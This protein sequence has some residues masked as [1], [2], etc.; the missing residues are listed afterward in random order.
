MAFD[1]NTNIASLQ[2]QQYLRTNSNFQAKTINEVTSGLRIVSSGDDAAGLAIANGYRSDQSVISQGVRNANDGLSQL[3]IAD[4]GISNISQLLDRART[5]ATQSASGTF[6]GDRGVLNSEFQSV[7]GEINR[8]AQAIGLNQGGILAKSLSVFIGGG[9]TSGTVS[10]N[11]NGS[12][13]LDLSKSTVDAKSL[14]LTGF[15]A[16]GTSTDIGNNAKAVNVSTILATS[17]NTTTEAVNGYTTFNFFGQGFSDT[18]GAGKLSVSVNLSSVTDANTLVN[19]VNSAI[20][21]T[22]LAGSP[23]ATAFK[24]ANVTASLVTDA[25]G[26][27][28]AFSSSATAFQAQAGDNV[29]SALLGNT[30]SASSPTGKSVFATTTASGVAAG[31]TAPGAAEAV[32]LRVSLNGVST[33]YA[34]GLATTDNTAAKVLAKV[35][36]ALGTTSGITASLDGSSNLVFKSSTGS[37]SLNV[38]TAG[39]ISNSLGLGTFQA[40]TQGSGTF[41]YT[42]TTGTGFVAATATQ[43][44][45]VSINGGPV[46]DLGAVVSGAS[47][48]TAIAALNVALT[49]NSSARASG[50]TASNNGGQIQITSLN[51]DNFRL[52]SVGGVATTF[53]FAAGV[54]AGAAGAAS[55]LTGTFAVAPGTDASGESQTGLLNFTGI[56][57]IGVT[58]AVT[59]SA[60]DQS[61]TLHSSSIT[62]D[63]TN[64]SNLDTAVAS[65]NK[66]LQQ[67][68][69]S[70]LQSVVAV[71][72]YNA[73]SNT[74]GIRFVSSAPSFQASLGTTANGNAAAATTVGISDG[75]QALGSQQGA[76]VASAVNGNGATA[77]ITNQSSAQAAVNT[78]ANAVSALGRAQAVVGKG[79]NQFNYAINLAQSQLTNLASAESQ[80]R[81]A[82]LASQA[83]N[84]TKAQILLQAGVAALAQANSA[85]QAVLALLKG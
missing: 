70:T 7:V 18:S 10:A 3:Q 74:E 31:A 27:H 67:T 80:I 35:N 50:L 55:S 42:S 85:P 25:N 81:D 51:G 8:Q 62:L 34:V 72:D 23:Q 66:Q 37:T 79:E 56:N 12:V 6:T 71:K 2:A 24:N 17:A 76:L 22:G 49:A 15:Q 28:L 44:F 54:T 4:G 20:Q 41:N 13:A 64:A 61:G 58:Q 75:S 63:T 16:V 1:I 30:V 60:T 57:T 78:L 65:I 73:T 43:N 53:G 45:Q 32:T 11:D 68:N 33:D 47:E 59:I 39:D 40:S 14:G 26:Q 46:V 29:A 19:A 48:T 36:T 5:L 52:N 83:A 69:D 82:D 21:A 38:Q 77:D 9:K 84:L